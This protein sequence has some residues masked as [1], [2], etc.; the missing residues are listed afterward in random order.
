MRREYL[1]KIYQCIFLGM[2]DAIINWAISEAEEDG[3]MLN[4]RS[5][6]YLLK[7]FMNILER[8]IEDEWSLERKFK[9]L[10]FN[11]YTANALVEHTTP[12]QSVKDCAIE[13]ISTVCSFLEKYPQDKI[14]RTMIFP[15]F[16]D[17]IITYK[18]VPNLEEFVEGSIPGIRKN[19]YSNKTTD[20]QEQYNTRTPQIPIEQIG[21]WARLILEAQAWPSG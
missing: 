13:Y 10:Q 15:L 16:K 5:I 1:L 2:N 6:Q 11:E 14:K 21:E 19:W 17:R 3:G 18:P 7:K 20:D 12:H 4:D 8:K 9:H